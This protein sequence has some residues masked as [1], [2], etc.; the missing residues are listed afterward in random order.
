MIYLDNSA[1]SYPKPQSVVSEYRKAILSYYSNPGRGG[2]ENA[3]KTQEK[4]Y[5]TR[6]KLA[7]FFGCEDE[8]NV[9]FTMN[10]TMAVNMV[11]KGILNEGDH[12]L[13]SD[14]EHNCVI[15]PL[16]TLKRQSKIKYDTFKVSF[17]DDAKTLNSI[18]E[19]VNESTKLIFCTHASNVLGVALP[20]EAIGAFCKEN[21]I[22]FAIDAAQSGGVLPIDMK[23][24][25]I[26]FLCLAPHKGL[27][28]PMGLGVL[29]TDGTPLKSFAEGGTGSAS[30]LLS[31]PQIMPDK[32]ESGTVNVP[33]IVALSS[34]IDYIRKVGREE[35]YQKEKAL[36]QQ[37]FLA[38]KRE[39]CKL[40]CDFER[41]R[42]FSPVLSFNI[43]NVS[44][45]ACAAYL[46]KN[47]I[48]VRAGLHCA[49]LPHRKIGTIEEGT[50]RISPSFFTTQQE[51]NYAI[52]TIKKLL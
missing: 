6:A 51:I 14:V 44:S 30:A 24:C 13:V 19:K 36:M 2:Y 48:Y 43:P 42:A 10:C 33:A 34:G 5:E 15:R 25:H 1:T 4:V 41:V 40:Y 50:V 8:R 52:S 45:E 29:L 28:S 9:V 3:L 22:H 32:L 17:Y 18:K 23:R 16:E 7:E 31:Q 37:L 35:I 49:A 47:G 20:I 26:S 12:V 27:Y 38:L 46:A 21:N 39:R 11:L